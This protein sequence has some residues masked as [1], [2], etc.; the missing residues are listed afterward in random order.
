MKKV[1]VLTLVGIL[2]LA[3]LGSAMAPTTKAGGEV[4]HES[5]EGTLYRCGPDYE[6]IC[7]DDGSAATKIYFGG[8]K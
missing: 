8:I 2:L 1:L 6:D 5:K 3:A 7:W 4:L